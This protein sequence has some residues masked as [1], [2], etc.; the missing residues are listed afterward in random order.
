MMLEV[1]IVA[2]SAQFD[3]IVRRMLVFAYFEL[4]EISYLLN[5]VGS[6]LIHYFIRCQ[7]ILAAS[8]LDLT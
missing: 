2:E 4:S 5:V 8:T 1:G 7:Q 3:E 6:Q